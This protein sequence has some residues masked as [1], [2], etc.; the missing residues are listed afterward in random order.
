MQGS[1][2]CGVVRVDK[3]LDVLANSYGEEIAGWDDE[4]NEEE[5]VG[6]GWQCYSCNASHHAAF[7]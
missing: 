1:R 4:G 5:E 2:H 3:K 7:L 6:G